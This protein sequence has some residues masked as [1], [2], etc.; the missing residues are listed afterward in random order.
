VNDLRF[1]AI[2]EHSYRTRV[3]SWC[4]RSWGKTTGARSPRLPRRHFG[5]STHLPALHS[6]GA[7]QSALAAH[8]THVPPLHAGVAPPQSLH[9]VHVPPP[10]SQPL[11][12]RTDVS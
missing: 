2:G 3:R 5:G 12:C 9:V 10:G 11:T 8:F 4:P 1:L 6:S 7:Q